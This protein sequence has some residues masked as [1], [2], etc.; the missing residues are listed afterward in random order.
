MRQS[1]GVL[2]KL[3]TASTDKTVIGN[4]I[5]IQTLHKKKEEKLII[6]LQQK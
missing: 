2:G 1:R 4:L 5:F 6:I 3:F